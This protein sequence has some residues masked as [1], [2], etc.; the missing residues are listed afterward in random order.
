MAVP[1]TE[2]AEELQDSK[3]TLSSED[4]E[5]GS[6]MNGVLVRERIKISDELRKQN[7]HGPSREV[8]RSTEV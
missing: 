7:G 2:K 5:W 6:L 1:G 3:K 4:S 8:D